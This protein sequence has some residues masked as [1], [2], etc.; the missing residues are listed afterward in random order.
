MA[1]GDRIPLHR[2]AVILDE[3]GCKAIL[4]EPSNELAV[5]LDLGGRLNRTPAR[6]E[7]RYIMSAG[8]AAELIADLTIGARAVGGPAWLEELDRELAAAKARLEAEG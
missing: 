2:D 4:T 5:V 8:Q 3:L 1:A 6:V 7:H